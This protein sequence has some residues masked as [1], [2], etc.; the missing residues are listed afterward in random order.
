MTGV[1][2]SV[3]QPSWG[4]DQRGNVNVNVHKVPTTECRFCGKTVRIKFM[5]GDW[6]NAIYP[7]R[8]LN[9]DGKPCA[10]ALH[11]IKRSDVVD[12]T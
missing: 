6:R 9:R 3:A 1:E 7:I 11:E 12:P 2:V 4:A 10:G 5:G 8:H